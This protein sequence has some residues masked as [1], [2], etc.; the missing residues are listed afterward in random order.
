LAEI[1][2]EVG[3]AVGD[4]YGTRGTFAL[5]YAMKAYVGIEA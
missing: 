1:L 3:D 5:V 4:M 2:P